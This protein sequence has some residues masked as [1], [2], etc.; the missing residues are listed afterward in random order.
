[1]AFAISGEKRES[2]GHSDRMK[3]LSMTKRFAATIPSL[4]DGI[5]L[6]FAR[7]PNTARLQTLLV[8]ERVTDFLIVP[9]LTSII[10]KEF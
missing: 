4:F 2:L 7:N 6:P 9:S 8:I 5:L 1:V 3:V 10:Q